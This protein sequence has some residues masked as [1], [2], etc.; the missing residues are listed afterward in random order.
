MMRLCFALSSRYGGIHFTKR[1]AVV[2]FETAPRAAFCLEAN[3]HYAILG[4]G[5]DPA[6][7]KWMAAR[8]KREKR[9]KR[10]EKQRARREKEERD[11]Y[12]GK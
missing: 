9:H 2:G 7:E 12:L 1:C 3:M 10:K 8:R 5:S 11:E 6:Y 4:D